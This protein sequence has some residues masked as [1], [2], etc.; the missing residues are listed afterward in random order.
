MGLREDIQT[1][2]GAAFDGDLADAV[3]VL[4]LI[5]ITGTYNDD[6]GDN[7]LT[8]VPFQTRGVLDKYE[9]IEIF[10]ESVRPTDVKAIILI[11]ELD[12]TPEIDDYIEYSGIGYKIIRVRSDPADAHWEL[13]CRR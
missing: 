7:T 5:K 2:I 6:P 1:D 13:Q 4:T 10:N 12:T 11:N 9:A 3:K 8:E